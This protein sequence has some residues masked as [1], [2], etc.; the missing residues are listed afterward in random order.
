LRH[1]TDL[2]D[3]ERGHGCELNFPGDDEA[4]GSCAN[5]DSRT[6]HRQALQVLPTTRTDLG[7][8]P[9]YADRQAVKTLMSDRRSVDL[10][11]NV[12]LSAFCGWCRCS[13]TQWSLLEARRQILS[14]VCTNIR[15]HSTHID[16]P[17]YHRTTSLGTLPDTPLIQ[18]RI[19]AEPRLKAR[20]HRNSVDFVVGKEGALSISKRPPSS[21]EGSL[22]ILVTNLSFGLLPPHTLGQ[23]NP[24]PG[25]QPF[26]GWYRVA[27]RIR[28]L[29]T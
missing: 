8:M 16:K 13:R 18:H 21:T 7:L 22:A 15:N 1:G 29:R 28:S 24:F 3:V 10:R 6:L 19:E 17:K 5:V 26:I 23:K 4:G 2:R 14:E 20:P 9:C 25:L 27:A 11:V 12:D